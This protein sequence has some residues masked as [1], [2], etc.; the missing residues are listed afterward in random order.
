MRFKG[1]I[2]A[3]TPIAKSAHGAA[4]DE[5]IV[6][7]FS[8]GNGWNKLI[9]CAQHSGNRCYDERMRCNAFRYVEKQH[10][11]P[12]DFLLLPIAIKKGATLKCM[13][14]SKQNISATGTAASGPKAAMARRRAKIPDVAVC[15]GKP[16][17]GRHF[18]CFRAATLWRSGSTARIWQKWQ[19]S[20]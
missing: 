16:L 1:R 14:F 6:S 4:A 3:V 10:V 2:A 9:P 20:F 18:E 15:P 11:N 7:I 8:S 5:S 12:P 13:A 17:N 19:G